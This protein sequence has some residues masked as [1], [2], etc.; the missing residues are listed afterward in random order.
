MKKILLFALAAFSVSAFSQTIPNNDFENWTTHDDP[1]ATG[2]VVDSLESGYWESGNPML[3]T[4]PF[5]AQGLPKGFMYDTSYAYSGN[6]AVAMRTGFLNGLVA[7]G[8]LFSGSIDESN[9]GI[10]SV[11]DNLNPLAPAT[12]GM[13]STFTP[14]KFKGFYFYQPNDE[15]QI[16]DSVTQQND[17]L[18]GTID[19]CKIA[20]IVHKW[21]PTLQKRD[22]IA[23]G[24]F[25][26]SDSTSIYTPFEI[27]L[28]YNTA[29]QGD[30]ISVLFLSSSRGTVFAGSAGSLLIVD[31]VSFEGNYLGGLEYMDEEKVFYFSVNNFFLESEQGERL[32]VYDMTG[33]NVYSKEF[34]ST[35]FQKITFEKNGTFIANIERDGQILKSIK[36]SNR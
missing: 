14:S 32:M 4:L 11:I 9:N 16:F 26:S 8:N 34:S 25:K 17:S 27:D 15:Y 12:T 21:N 18:F 1:Q 19:T 6:H 30:S 28:I 29:G 20:C 10:Q 13:P 31:S 33:R 7:T 36:V 22:T 5:L 35:G 3:V 24:E 2:I 23:Y